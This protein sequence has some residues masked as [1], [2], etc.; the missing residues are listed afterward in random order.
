MVRRKE[1]KHTRFWKDS[2]TSTRI[3]FAVAVAARSTET[4]DTR[5]IPTILS[6]VSIT[7]PSRTANP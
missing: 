1:L 5:L 4:L 3:S 6:T 2:I 7:L